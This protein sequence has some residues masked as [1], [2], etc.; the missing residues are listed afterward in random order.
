MVHW[1]RP[2]LMMS[3]RGDDMQTDP[4]IRRQMLSDGA[5]AF[6][7]TFI[8]TAQ[9]RA[10]VLFGVGAGGDPQRHLPLLTTLAERGFTIAAPHFG[11]MKSLVPTVAE[12]ETRARRH[13]LAFN[14]IVRTGV[15]AAGVGHSIGGAMMLML[16]GATAWTMPG[17]PARVPTEPR[18]ERLALLAPA[19][20]FFTGPGALGMVRVPIRAWVG[21]KD[22]ITPPAGAQ[23]IK[24]RLAGEAEM[25]VSVVADAGHFSFMNVPPPHATETLPDRDAF[26]RQLAE[27]VAS[28]VLA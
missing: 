22:S 1:Q 13:Q 2:L 15:P 7:V 27:E 10:S 24:D 23:S 26:L 11:R 25:E 19:T 14:E 18:L 28:F 21:G 17:L 4:R 9:P 8:D 12:M 6:E 20:A 5:E 3:A 16:A